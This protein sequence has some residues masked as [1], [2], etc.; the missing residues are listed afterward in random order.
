MSFKISS[1]LSEN[2]IESDVSSYLGY[3]TPFWQK[4]YRLISIN[5]QIT[6]ADKLFDRFIPIYFQFKVSHGLKPNVSILEKYRN[7]PLSNIIEFRNN[8]NYITNPILYF[9]LRKQ[10]KT[11]PDYQHNIL[12][13]LN[14]HPFQHAVYIAP[15]TLELKEYENMLNENWYYR[16][17]KR[18]YHLNDVEIYDSSEDMSI[19]FSTIPFLR[20]H[21]AIPPHKLTDTDK[22]HYSFSKSGGDVIWHGGEI[23]NEDYRLFNFL[24]KILNSFSQNKKNEQ[25]QITID[26]Y[27]D[28]LQHE[29]NIHLNINNNFN[30]LFYLSNMLKEIYNIKL[31]FLYDTCED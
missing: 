30:K 5:E 12:F 23:F 19:E 24:S 28:Y 26:N 4:R 13:R 14:S 21:I 8:N 18:P 31:M 10:A 6:G 27:L 20:H 15:L 9:P 2:Q 22:H 16:L 29:L 11:A 17:R 25:K 1:E 7:K 3:I